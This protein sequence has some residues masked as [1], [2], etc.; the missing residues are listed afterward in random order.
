VRTMSPRTTISWPLIVAVRSPPW[1]PMSQ[2][3]PFQP[4]IWHSPS[5][6]KDRPLIPG[7]AT[8]G[9]RYQ[10]K[11]RG[12]SSLASEYRTPARTAS[13]VAAIDGVDTPEPSGESGAVA[14]GA[15]ARLRGGV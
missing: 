4:D 14:R 2:D 1:G 6:F 3:P 11:R 9:R 13:S 15:D 7:W 5:C 12:R 10:T 8:A